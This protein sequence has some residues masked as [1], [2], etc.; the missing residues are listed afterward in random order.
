MT[1]FCLGILFSLVI[2]QCF[3][4]NRHMV[5]KEIEDIF[6]AGNDSPISNSVRGIQGTPG[7][8][9]KSG[10]K[11][12]V[13][14]PGVPGK[15][16]IVDYDKI[17]KT[18]RREIASDSKIMKDRISEIE[19]KIANLTAQNEAMMERT[20]EERC[21][22][23]FFGILYN[24]TCFWADIFLKTDMSLAKAQQRCT[25]KGSRLADINSKDHFDA[26]MT[27]LRPK[28][29]AGEPHLLVWTGMKRNLT[30]GDAILSTG[31]K[32]PYVKPRSDASKWSKGEAKRTL[33]YLLVL[34][35]LEATDQ[36]FGAI[37]DTWEA[38]G[39]LCQTT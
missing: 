3:G 23:T 26:I 25:N 33:A 6:D 9:G 5:C 20:A 8:R 31:A 1:I 35:D 27:Y 21:Q 38:H 19:K 13:G 17:K 28:I 37:W 32:A 14:P 39:V 22:G 34:P 18:I 30:S 24:S 12:E 10:I 15:P 11:G 2:A 16:G 7:K 29:V 4:T 36:G